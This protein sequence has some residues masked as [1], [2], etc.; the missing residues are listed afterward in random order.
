LQ[1]ESSWLLPTEW[2]RR[3]RY[4][5]SILCYSLLSSLPSLLDSPFFSSPSPLFFIP[6]SSLPPPI[7]SLRSLISP[8]FS[9]LLPFSFQVTFYGNSFISDPTG[10]VLARA[11]RDTTEVIFA[12][13]FH[14]L[15]LSSCSCSCSSSSSSSFCSYSR[16][17][18]HPSFSL[19]LLL[20]LFL[21]LLSSLSFLLFLFFFVDLDFKVFAKWRELFPLLHQRKP[22]LY[23]RLTEGFKA[24][25]A[26]RWLQ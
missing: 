12:G 9:K 19:L 17:H 22:A 6:P 16:P 1:T 8:L 10:K 3:T 15:L 13:N 4:P 11:G 25:V 2:E 18:S 7:S 26:P 24:Q 21:L 20:P 14:S 5:C 23:H